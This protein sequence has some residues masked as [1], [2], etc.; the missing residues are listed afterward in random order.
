VWALALLGLALSAPA[1]SRAEVASPVAT[2]TQ[3]SNQRTLSRWAYPQAEASVHAD[4]SSHSRR[5]GRLRFLTSD[6]QA[7]VYLA[8]SATTL[9]TSGQ[10]IRIELPG[11][12]NGQTG[13]VPRADLG[14]LHVVR[15]YLLIDR[16]TLH[17]RLFRDGRLLFNAPIGVGK[18]STPTPGGEF[19]VTEK[20]ITLNAPSYG[21]YA[22]GTSAY[23]PTL[24]EWPGGGV[25]GI[26]G[27]NEPRLIPGRPSHGC[28]R[29]RN[30][31]I[32][33]LWHTI[34]IGTPIEI[35]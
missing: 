20:L 8:L 19:Y 4:P 33:R 35:R 1:V 3:L 10:W 27:T 23:A 31:D 11:R 22:L 29:M 7:Q 24:S 28:V 30:G 13:W 9:P 14:P 2:L 32:S 26:H 18:P 12:P 16:R 34:A 25:V 5:L 17:A 15:D 21:P 6:G